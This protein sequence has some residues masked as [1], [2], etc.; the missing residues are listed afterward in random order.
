MSI[1][2]GPEI[3]NNG[4]VLALDATNSK[5]YP[6]SG[7]TWFDVS[8]KGNHCVFSNLPTHANGIFTFDGIANQGTITNNDTMNFSSEQTVIMI[9]NHTFTS[10]RRNPWNQ[11]YG[12]Y[13]TWTHESGN[14]MN[15]YYGDAGVNNV[16]YTALGS[17]TTPRSVWNVLCVVRD[18]SNIRWYQNGVATTSQANPYSDLATTAANITIGNGYAG[19]WE[20]NMSAVFAYTRALTAAE[21]RKNFN[22]IRNRYSI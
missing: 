2:A 8:G 22:A 10:G 1:F 9:L 20:G 6:G 16:P 11:A 5:S 14:N 21:V 13:G 19:F 18:I 4:L 7:N 17:S 15:Y 3:D 12:G